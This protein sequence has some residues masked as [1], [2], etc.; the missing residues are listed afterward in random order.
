LLAANVMAT[1]LPQPFRGIIAASVYRFCR[2]AV[3]GGYTL[4]WPAVLYRW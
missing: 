4:A 1:T 3:T 2:L